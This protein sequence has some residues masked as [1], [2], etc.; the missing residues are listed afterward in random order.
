MS[1]NGHQTREPAQPAF[2]AGDNTSPSQKT[3]LDTVAPFCDAPAPEFHAL[4]VR[5]D[6]RQRFGMSVYILQDGKPVQAG[7]DCSEAARKGLAMFPTI[8]R[9]KRPI[10][11]LAVLLILAMLPTAGGCGMFRKQPKA[12]PYSGRGASASRTTQKSDGPLGRVG[13]LFSNDESESSKSIDG[14]LSQDRPGW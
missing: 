2:Q 13:S 12:S 5:Y 11:V 4:P 10:S 1:Q 14:F 6:L 9:C 8:D 7:S 3:G